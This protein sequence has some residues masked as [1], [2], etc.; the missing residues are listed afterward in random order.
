MLSDAE[1]SKLGVRPDRYG[2]FG[3]P[4]ASE[5]DKV[6]AAQKNKHLQIDGANKI[7]W[8]PT[9]EEAQKVKQALSGALKSLGSRSE[10]P[11]QNSSGSA[12]SSEATSEFED[13]EE[14][15]HATPGS[16]DSTDKIPVR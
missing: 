14:E 4:G 7:V 2:V 3:Q 8:H 13:E 12:T 11:K 15:G 6:V 5:F 9:K 10:I 16:E 1:Q